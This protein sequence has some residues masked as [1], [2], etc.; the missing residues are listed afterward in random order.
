MPTPY[1]KRQQ[2][3]RD[4]HWTDIVRGRVI[5]G[6]YEND[7][8]SQCA[9]AAYVEW[10]MV[11]RVRR[12]VVR[13]DLAMD[14][15]GGESGNNV[16]HGCWPKSAHSVYGGSPRR[17]LA[18]RT[19][20]HTPAVYGKL[21]SRFWRVVND[22]GWLRKSRGVSSSE[23]LCRSCIRSPGPRTMSATTD[24]TNGGP[25]FHPSPTPLPAGLYNMHTMTCTT[26]QC[27][28]RGKYTSLPLP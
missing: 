27:E 1:G 15:R 10:C 11:V 18:H 28:F 2:R 22:D 20:H 19:L 6:F 17:P 25:K 13:N 23:S 5:V 12:S 26:A 16:V 3:R 9:F 7:F 8:F 14:S 24:R 21:Y 4:R